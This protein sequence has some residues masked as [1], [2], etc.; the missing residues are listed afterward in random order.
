[1]RTGMKDQYLKKKSFL[2]YFKPFMQLVG[3]RFVEK[4]ATENTNLV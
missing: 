2:F 3:S 1:M 4:R